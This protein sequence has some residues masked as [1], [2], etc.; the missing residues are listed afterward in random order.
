MPID[1][2]YKY[3][4]ICL[5]NYYLLDLAKLWQVARDNS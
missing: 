4:Y 1:L 5:G 2:F 3:L